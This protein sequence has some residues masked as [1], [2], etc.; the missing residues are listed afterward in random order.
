MKSIKLF[1]VLF[2]LLAPVG[3]GAQQYEPFAVISDTHIGAPNSIYPSFAA[4]ME[5]QKIGMVIHTGDAIDAPGKIKQWETFLKL[6][7]ENITLH[8]VP[9]NHDIK[10]RKSLA[11]YLKYFEKT[12]YSFAEGDTL[13]ILL[14]TEFPGQEGR[15]AGDQ[16]AWLKTELAK[17]FKYKFI[18]LHES[19]YPII[20]LHGLDRHAEERDALHKLFVDH[21]VSLVVAGP[22][23]HVQ[24]LGTGRDHLHHCGNIRR[25]A[26]LSPEKRRFL[27]VYD[28][29]EKKTAAT[30]SP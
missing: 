23:S 3:I 4:K 20:P 16:L 13:F 21:G 10:D 12:Y 30:S 25:M 18:F 29:N 6:T 9:G 5:Q 8:L 26:P 27:P 11:V 28:G 7:G 1:L 15:I 2:L 17:P 14:N 19:L 24:P 22:R